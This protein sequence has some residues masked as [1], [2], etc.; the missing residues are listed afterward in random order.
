MA[1]QIEKRN[2]IDDQPRKALGVKLPFSAK[3]VFT[4]T[5]TSKEAL[6]TNLFNFFLT[7]RTERFLN[8]EFGSGLR[9]Q[10][11]ENIT[12]EKLT[13]IKNRLEEE[14]DLYFPNL[15]VNELNLTSIPDQN[16]IQF[17]FKYSVEQTNIEDEIEI[18][19]EI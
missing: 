3:A 18:N 17:Y 8:P 5:F 1:Y 16:L 14:I 15:I 7:G 6:R 19:I 13:T 10:L 12:P 9:N 2:P 4:P 11:F